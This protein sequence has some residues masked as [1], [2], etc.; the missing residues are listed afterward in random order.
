MAPFMMRFTSLEAIAGRLTDRNVP[1]QVPE[2][3]H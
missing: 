1:Q 3:P 2:N